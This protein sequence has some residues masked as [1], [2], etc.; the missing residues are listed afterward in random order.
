MLFVKVHVK[1]AEQYIHS[2][3]PN[4]NSIVVKFDLMSSRLLM[5]CL[6]SQYKNS[7]NRKGFFRV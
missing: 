3:T 4:T 1:E 6:D 7:H 2:L 5:K